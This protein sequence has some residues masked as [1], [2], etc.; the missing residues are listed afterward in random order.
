MSKPRRITE[1][2]LTTNPSISDLIALARVG[3]NSR[4]TI[5]SLLN[6]E[7]PSTFG[8]TTINGDLNVNGN[9][10]VSTI[11]S[12]SIIYE[13]GSTIFGNSLDD[14]HDFIGDVS[15]T[16][17]LFVSGGTE[18]GGDIYP[19]TPQGAR[20]G[21]PENPFRE[22]YLQSGSITIESDTPG[23]PSAKISNFNGNVD[24]KAAGFSVTSGSI[25]PF[26]IN[27]QGQ[28][29]IQNKYQDPQNEAI[30][31]VIGNNEGSQ[32]AAVNPGGMIHITGFDGVPNR[33]VFDSYGGGGVFSQVILRNAAGTAANPTS[34]VAGII[35]RVA[36]S[37]YITDIGFGIEGVTGP[38][39][40]MN[41]YTPGY[42]SGS[43]ETMIRFYATADNELDP[44]GYSAV[45]KA[46]GMEVTGS[47]DISGDYTINGNSFSSS[48]FQSSSISGSVI[49]FTKGDTTTQQVQIPK[50]L[51]YSG[52][53]WARYNDT[54]YTTLSAFTIEDGADVV[55][56]CNGSGSIE[57]HMHSTVSFYTGAGQKLQ[58]ENAGDVYTLT[59]DFTMRA[60]NNPSDGDY[61]RIQMN[62]T[63]GTPYTRV[64]RDLFFAKKD[65][66]WHKF[67]EI[68]QY[69]ADADFVANGNEINVIPSGFDIEVADVV[70][71]I[72]RTQ[73]HS[74]H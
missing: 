25:S 60:S 47:V 36:T 12:A 35:G 38:P 22:I 23:D 61:V 63:T 24:I 73:N 21:T 52:L 8:T 69:Y 66:E 54:T 27:N 55:L 18:L 43:R 57:T 16:G 50:G 32:S 39:A 10:N 2:P 48:L 49:Q 30:F 41:F 4:V 59:V 29:K 68:F 20:L 9:L 42:R 71:F 44:N 72:Q 62:N 28:I 17:S 65:T 31:Q 1:L 6:A 33:N 34:T 5:G 45:I 26:I 58:A 15:I 56:P 19:Q 70:I 3:S 14:T 7:L 74:Q 40:S 37:G 53:G 46:E 11:V 51:G 13:S 67:H 64:G